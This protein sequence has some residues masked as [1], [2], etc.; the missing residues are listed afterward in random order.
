[1]HPW[2]GEQE[3]QQKHE[4]RNKEYRTYETLKCA[5]GF[6]KE[7]Y[8]WQRNKKQKVRAHLYSRIPLVKWL[9]H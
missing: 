5:K 1:M 6:L 7:P 9:L 3:N 2:A 4:K 8:K